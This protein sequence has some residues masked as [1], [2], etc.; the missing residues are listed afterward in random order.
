MMTTR[1]GAVKYGEPQV[2][3]GRLRRKVDELRA[4]LERAPTDDHDAPTKASSEGER[5]GSAVNERSNER[6]SER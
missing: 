4:S 3:S 1:C 2:E 5:E 6:R